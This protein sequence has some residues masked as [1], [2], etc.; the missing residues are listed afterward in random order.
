MK[1]QDKH[2]E[3]IKKLRLLL[4]NFSAFGTDL[5]AYSLLIKKSL[6]IK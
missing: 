2:D 6:Y 3:V 4:G 5:D 1:T